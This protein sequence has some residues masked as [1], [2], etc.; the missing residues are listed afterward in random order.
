M[1]KRRVF[2]IGCGMTKV[3]KYLF[4]FNYLLQLLLLQF[5]KP[6]RRENFDY[7]DMAK[8]AVTKALKDAKIDYK[9]IKQA[10]VGFCFG[11]HQKN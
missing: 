10:V 6:G 9:E 8:E 7:P 5:E 2:V 1:S 11:K 4:P 3:I